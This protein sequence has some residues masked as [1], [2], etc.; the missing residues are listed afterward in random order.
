[1]GD[2]YLDEVLGVAK[3]QPKQAQA[4][5]QKSSGDWYMDEILQVQ[6]RPA[7]RT[8]PANPTLPPGGAMPQAQRRPQPQAAPPPAQP[9]PQAQPPVA[10]MPSVPTPQPAPVAPPPQ[11][12]DAK[13]AEPDADSWF[14][15][16][17]QDIRGKR[18]PRYTSLPSV[19]ETGE[20]PL[21]DDALFKLAGQGDAAYGD[22]LQ[23][24]L[25]NRFLRRFKDANG[26]EIIGYRGHDGKE[27]LAYVN[28]PSWEW[29]D[30]DRGIS[31]MVPYVAGAG[32]AGKIMGKAAPWLIRA[33]VQGAVAGVTSIGQDIAA[34][35]MGS[36]R[37]VDPIKALAATAGGVVGESIAPA[38]AYGW[39]KL[40]SEPRLFNRSTGTLTEQGIDA[41]KRAGLDPADL[42]PD[43]AKRFSQEFARTGN[44]KAAGLKTDLDEVGIPSTQAQRTK[45]HRGLM[46]EQALRDGVWGEGPAT[47]IQNFDRRQL[48]AIEAATMGDIAPGKPGMGPMLAPHRSPADYTPGQVGASIGERANMALEA[49]RKAEGDAWRKVPEL[50]ATDQALGTLPQHINKA[51][52]GMRI[53]EQLH[54]VSTAMARDIQAFM[55][56]K[57]PPSV[58]PFLTNDPARNVNVFREMMSVAMR[59]MERGA[60]KTAA[61]RIYDGLNSWIRESA[62]NGMLQ[63]AGMDASIAAANMATARGISRDLHRVFDGDPKTGGAAIMKTILQGADSP[64]QIVQALF[65]GP[66]AHVPR[67][68][69]ISAINSLKQATQHLPKEEGEALIGDLRLAHW[70]RL[71]QGPNGEVMNPQRMVGAIKASLHQGRDI[72][73]TLYT[74]EQRAMA[75]RI[76]RGLENGPTFRDW[77]IKINSSRSGTTVANLMQDFLGMLMGAIGLKTSAGRGALKGLG[78]FSGYN[79]G[80]AASA[81]SQSSPARIGTMPAA[82]GADLGARSQD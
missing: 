54:P 18:D 74:P 75:H 61:G 20:I 4:P 22:F 58:A 28:K 73:Q 50:L 30:V 63:A 12:D 57:A 16:R 34:G 2:W 80:R 68:G 64:A 13:Y 37:G 59:D 82:I 62:E 60:D 72:W 67:R 47:V 11:S 19:Q 41:A 44:A 45:S 26:Y 81:V 71:V 32:V 79:T 52:G 38:V 6:D 76:V 42:T 7:N 69:A 77:T 29:N 10:A 36:E 9:M 66:Q 48:S 21:Q 46:D 17:W 56:G 33:P 14:G 23:S 15:R 49:A 78:E 31:G 8:L 55:G 40:V 39:R 25:G 43:M 35:E 65:Q 3:P 24:Q 53:S 1:M 5:Q 51:L 27:Q 70:L